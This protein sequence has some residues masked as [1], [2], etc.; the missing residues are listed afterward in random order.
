[1]LYHIYICTCVVIL[2][3]VYEYYNDYPGCVRELSATNNVLFQIK[4]VASRVNLEIIE[5]KVP[6]IEEAKSFEVI[7]N[8]D[9]KDTRRANC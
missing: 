7:A 4:K 2:L 8:D 6:T 5:E 1:M 3:H 9:D